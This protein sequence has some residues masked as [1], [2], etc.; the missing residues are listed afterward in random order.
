MKT[1]FYV[2][3]QDVDGKPPARKYA[4]RSNAIAYFESMVGYTVAQ[5]LADQGGHG[6]DTPAAEVKSIRGV[7][8]FG[9]V[10][11]FWTVEKT[12]DDLAQ[13]KADRDWRKVRAANKAAAKASKAADAALDDFNYVGSR[14]HY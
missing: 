12:D 2:Q 6:F 4:K 5:V 13:E 9:T 10:V 14:H 7:S 3:T 11:R 8:M 1:I